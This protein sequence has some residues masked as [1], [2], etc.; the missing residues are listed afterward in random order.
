MHKRLMPLL[1][2]PRCKGK[3][4]HKAATS[5]MVCQHDKLAFPVRNGIPVLLEMDAK[6]IEA[7]G[8][9]QHTIYN[10]E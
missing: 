3:L 8:N 4:E 5:E 9:Q 1:V 6:K 10:E 7:H 2:C